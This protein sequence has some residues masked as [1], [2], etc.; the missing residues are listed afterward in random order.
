MKDSFRSLGIVRVVVHEQTMDERKKV[1]RCVET[2]G[3]H[4]FI[5]CSII[6]L[7]RR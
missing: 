1:M 2:V 6:R 4:K 3:G 5:F 7:L